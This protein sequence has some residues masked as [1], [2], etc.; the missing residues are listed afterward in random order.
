[1]N[2]AKNMELIFVAA[3]ALIGVSG[4]ADAAPQAR[5]AKAA[6]APVI[7]GKMQV[8]TISAKRLAPVPSAVAK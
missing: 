6:A 5:Q 2:I 4:L 8:V 3:L 1:M 7:E